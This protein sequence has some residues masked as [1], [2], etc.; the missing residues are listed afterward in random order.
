MKVGDRLG[1]TSCKDSR[2]YCWRQCLQSEK[3]TTI[4]FT[5]ILLESGACAVL[6]GFL[7]KMHLVKPTWVKHLAHRHSEV[8]LRFKV[9][10]QGRVVSRMDSPV[11]VEVIEPGCVRSATG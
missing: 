1:W 2:Q 8:P 7:F 3:K 9:L 10:W 6:C 5:A 11:G 4:I